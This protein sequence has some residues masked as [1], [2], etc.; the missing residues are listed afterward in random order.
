MKIFISLL[1]LIIIF[2]CNILPESGNFS[3]TQT[4][5]T[6]SG[7]LDFFENNKGDSTKLNEF[8]QELKDDKKIPFTHKDTVL[9]LYKGSASSVSW[10]GDFSSWGQKTSLATKGTRIGTSDIFYLK[11]IFP[12]DARI[13]YKI[14]TGNTWILDPNNPNQQWSGFGPNSELKMPDYEDSPYEKLQSGVQAGI[15][16]STKTIS[17]SYLSYTVGYKVWLPADYDTSMADGYKMLY[18]T[19]GHEYADSRLGALPNVAANLLYEKK[20]EPIIIIFVSPVNPSNSNQNR[21]ETE[22]VLNEKYSNF[23][24]NELIPTVE[25]NYN[26]TRKAEDRGILGTSLGGLHSA[27]IMATQSEHFKRIGIH[28][29]A[30]WYR[31]TIFDLVSNLNEEPELIYMTTGTINDTEV[32]ADRMRDLFNSKSWN[33]GY[34]K[35]NEGHSWGN[36]SGTM[37]DMLMGLYPTLNTSIENK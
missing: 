29:P 31:E 22:Y 2:S 36:W 17:S 9:F 4:E 33:S 12:S 14:V 16:S 5:I 32:Q 1:S 24:I 21:R 35:V 37:D 7:I 11:H 10:Q 30:F 6:V 25:P 13:D 26:T 19:D 28:S 27:Y 20:I 34:K 23:L 8:W 18:V 3:N 15:L